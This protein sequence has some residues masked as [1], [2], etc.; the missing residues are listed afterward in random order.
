MRPINSPRRR[1]LGARRPHT[2]ARLFLLLALLSAQALG[3][4]PAQRPADGGQEGRG[5]SVRKEGT[6]PSEREST[7]PP[8]RD[9]AGPRGER[10]ELVLQTGYAAF[11]ATGLR[12]S[13]D[14][15]LLATTTLNSS[16]VK[17]W[18]T[19]TGREL[20]TLAAGSVAG[21]QGELSGVSAVAFSRDGRLIA[22]GGRDNAVTVWEV[23]TGRELRQLTTPPDAIYAA[24]GVF[25]LVFGPEGGSLVSFGDAVRVWNLATGKAEATTAWDTLAGGQ[26]FV[27][28][29]ALTPDGRR[30]AMIVGGTGGSE[31]RSAH[32]LD[33]A[34]GRATP[35]TP[36]PEDLARSSSPVL[37]FAPDGRLLAAAVEYGAGGD[38]RLK[39]WDVSAGSAGRA[40]A[41]VASGQMPFI[42]FSP[43]GRTL[44][45]PAAGSVRLFD[46]ATNRLLRV[47]APPDGAGARPAEQRFTAAAFSPD[48][49]RLATSGSDT[50]VTVWDVETGRVAVRAEGRVNVA[51]AAS[52]S[53][54]GARLYTGSR[55]LWDVAT[56][57]GLRVP[58]A[59]AGLVVGTQSGD[60]RLLALYTPI[61]SDRIGLYDAEQRRTLAQIP[62]PPGS[63][64]YTAAF[65]PDGRLL[66]ATFW[67]NAGTVGQPGA[68]QS[69]AGQSGGSQSGGGKP[70]T[71][72]MMM[73]A[74]KEAAKAAQKDPSAYMRVYTEAMARLSGRAAG[75]AGGQADGQAGR[76][77]GGQTGG[78]TA[79]VEGVVKVWET[80]TGRETRTINVPAANPLV[81]TRLGHLAFSADG[82]T[83]AVA[84]VRGA[85]VTL[86]DV[87]SGRRL[88]ALG[89]PV[90]AAAPAGFDRDVEPGFGAGDDDG[91]GGDESA[92]A[93]IAF[94][95]DGRFVAVGG[96]EARSGFDASALTQAAATARASRDPAAAREAA[97]QMARQALGEAK[98]SGTLRVYE[99]ATG[100]E[101]RAFL[102][103][104]GA[105]GAVAFS[106]DGR[107]L[108]SASEE[109]VVKVWDVARGAEL[110]T[111]SGHTAKITSL[112]FNPAGTLLASTGF[113]GR[114]LL[115]DA[116]TGEQLATLV[117]LGEGD[118]LAVTPD[119]L[120]DGSPAAW[121]QILW[122]FSGDTF[123][124]APVET[125]FNEFFRP[126]LL[127]EIFAGQRPRAPR[128]IA[129]IDRRQPALSIETDRQTG[130]Q[131]TERAVGVRVRVSSASAGAKDVRLFRNGS[132]VKVWRGDVLAGRDSVTLEATVPVTAGP[133]RFTAYAFNR[134]NVKSADAGAE[135][136]GA[137]SLRRAGTAYV[138]AVGVNRYENSQYDLRYAVADARDFAAEVRERLSA[139]GQY[140]AVEVV[141]LF[142]TEAT[143]ANLLDALGR[144]AGR[145]AAA[146]QG[147]PESLSRLAAARPEDAVFV[148]FAGHG[149]AQGNRFYL[150]PHDL[151]YAGAPGAL[152][153]SSLRAML[154]RGVSDEEL[155]AAFEG[156][157]A[158]RLLLVIDACN[159]G[160]ALEAEERRR[161]P[162]NSKGLA[163][164]AYE[165]G[166]YV[167]T[168]AQ[169]Y[170]A[171]LEASQLGHGLLTY[172]LIEEGLKRM[173]A[174]GEPRDGTLV[175]KE[176][177]DFATVRVP[178]MQSE[179]ME[180]ARSLGVS[181]NF[182]VAGAPG[183]AG[184]V[185]RPRAFYRRELEADPLVLA[186]SN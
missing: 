101:V 40:L 9:A 87:A 76:Q 140:S 24:A 77:A 111:L 3:Q 109:N 66:A 102:G 98:V 174:D 182:A 50:G 74:A 138:V 165:K 8:E 83:L 163:Q 100:R 70:Y 6:R 154:G 29:Y 158:G 175:A 64:V 137:D 159:S 157:D 39:V 51:Q 132:L 96:R 171:A 14:G 155:Q 143:K 122:R 34:T 23:A 82:R 89:A 72:E 145:G 180:Q 56:G 81:M 183:G 20:R 93:S 142:D 124:V 85:E 63:T 134:D 1:G 147:A 92:V 103:H 26:N 48:G 149:T 97:R 95:A 116:A 120:F 80:A 144:L 4:A 68:G 162:M 115:W 108:A 69:G 84:A 112:T 99:A 106:R 42:S 21:A 167:L 117:S 35:G 58:A 127:A 135:V 160:Q 105:V 13:P 170:Q 5:V 166:M 44:A 184:E 123:D 73:K 169:S 52:F 148:Y 65:S 128:D 22:A 94:S 141:T 118:W 7:T 91:F 37:S 55:T 78:Q 19:S 90:R 43:D 15:R 10:P 119:G 178:Q 71:A 25:F 139:A 136:T 41:E 86:W 177:L 62:S 161:G 176:W 121:R 79:S 113:D 57:T 59:E 33:L 146:R 150:L 133:N 61:R 172:V 17:L 18:D 32:L 75:Q 107:L 12:F 152:D 11:G 168:A 186:R 49:R 151:G 67:P 125:F 114:T 179:K 88:G 47:V 173:A 30:L 185:Q 156:L 54:D 16:Q 181:L 110:R 45:L 153:E 53:P 126:G 60:G 129:L 36:L 27:G 2:A 131:A 31:R 164:L 28:G 46:L 130:A 104:A 38:G